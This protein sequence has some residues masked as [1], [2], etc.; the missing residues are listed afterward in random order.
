MEKQELVEL[1]NK[2]KNGDE[3]AYK[4][5]NNYF[6]DKFVNNTMEQ[7]G[8][9]AAVANEIVDK[10]MFKACLNI[11][12]LD[13]PSLVEI[14]LMSLVKEKAIE[15]IPD[16]NEKATSAIDQLD[17]LGYRQE[18]QPTSQTQKNIKKAIQPRERISKKSRLN[19]F[20]KIIAGVVAALIVITGGIIYFNTDNSLDINDDTLLLGFIKTDAYDKLIVENKKKEADKKAEEQ[21]EID[22]Q[23]AQLKSV[24]NSE[25]VSQVSQ[26]DSNILNEMAQKADQKIAEISQ[27]SSYI[28]DYVSYVT[29]E[30]TVTLKSGNLEETA[31]EITI[32]YNYYG[33]IYSLSVNGTIYYYCVE[34]RDVRKDGTNLDLDSIYS[35]SSYLNWT[36]LELLKEYKEDYSSNVNWNF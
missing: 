10:A 23:K 22:S 34:F 11:Q 2:W 29:N 12:Q 7:N 35:E 28:G 14:W 31:E 8:F 6:H 18:G 3:N 36:D 4:Q 16:E 5:I 15:L 25:Y 33:R 27:P 20:V 17:A 24:D 30:S 21:K 9:S 19:V 13:D 26:I 1:V 32:D